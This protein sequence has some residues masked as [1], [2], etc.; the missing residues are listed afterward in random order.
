MLDEQLD[1][2]LHSSDPALRLVGVVLMFALVTYRVIIWGHQAWVYSYKLVTA[3][4]SKDPKAIEEARKSN[5]PDV[6]RGTGLIAIAALAFSATLTANG[7][8]RLARRPPVPLL[9]QS[10]TEE[11][12]TS[13]CTSQSCPGGKCINGK[14]TKMAERETAERVPHSGVEPW[15]V[16]RGAE[17]SDPPI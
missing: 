1:K 8:P 6:P 16:D 17:D 14:C 4:R 9:P 5:P 12:S 10:S 2:L 3:L 11:G 13:K 7:A 15:I